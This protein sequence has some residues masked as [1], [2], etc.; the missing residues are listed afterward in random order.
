MVTRR[1]AMLLVSLALLVPLVAVVGQGTARAQ[2]GGCQYNQQTCDGQ[3]PLRTLGPNGQVCSADGQQ[4][5][6]TSVQGGYVQEMWSANCG[7]NWAQ[8]TQWTPTY[9]YLIMNANITRWSDGRRYDGT[10][11][12]WSMVYSPMV[13]APTTPAQA[14]GSMNNW[15]GGCAPWG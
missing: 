7:T 11:Y 9:Y 13:F 15:P 1:L 8:T 6:W 5:E 4:V 2:I 12:S 14:C 3:D 10:W